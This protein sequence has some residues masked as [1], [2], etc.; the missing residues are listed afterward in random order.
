[1]FKMERYGGIGE[2]TF[3]RFT[4]NDWSHLTVALN[5]S[6]MYFS[7]D[8]RIKSQKPTQRISKDNIQK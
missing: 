6:G 8:G 5:D 4:T 3:T 7:I 2:E 1:M